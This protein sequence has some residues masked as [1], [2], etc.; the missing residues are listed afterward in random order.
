MVDPLLGQEY[1]ERELQILCEGK[2]VSERVSVCACV[3]TCVCVCHEVE[4]EMLRK[5]KEFI[6]ATAFHLAISQSYSLPHPIPAPPSFLPLASLSPPPSLRTMLLTAPP[7][8]TWPRPC[9]RISAE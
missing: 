1:D 9:A 7:F 4:G 2:Q 5:C 3:H 6:P 8:E